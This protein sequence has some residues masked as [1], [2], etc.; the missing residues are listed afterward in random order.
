[1]Q[2]SISL[3]K[4]KGIIPSR[5]LS[6][7]FDRQDNPGKDIG[8]NIPGRIQGRYFFSFGGSSNLFCPNSKKGNGGEMAV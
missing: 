4:N 5:R 2:I 1:M 6:T 8:Q 7:V 3:S